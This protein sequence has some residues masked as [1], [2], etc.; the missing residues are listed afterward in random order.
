MLVNIEIHREY[1]EGSRGEILMGFDMKDAEVFGMLYNLR[2]RIDRPEDLE[3]ID[4][5]I[6]LLKND[7]AP[8]NGYH[9]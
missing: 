3:A 9:Y 8:G 4:M 1:P 6:R 2:G 5:C 7:T